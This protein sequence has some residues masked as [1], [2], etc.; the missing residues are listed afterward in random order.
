MILEFQRAVHVNGT[1]YREGEVVELPDECSYAASCLRMGYA[2]LAEKIVE[3][4]EA[5][6]PPAVVPE[7]TVTADE[8]KKPKP[9][10]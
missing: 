9:R 4:I 1:G 10:K 2:K 3:K 8:P 7:V 6:T 5:V